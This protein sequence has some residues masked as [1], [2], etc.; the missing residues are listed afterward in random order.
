MNRLVTLRLDRNG[1]TEKGIMTIGRTIS[2]ALSLEFFSLCGNEFTTL[3]MTV[4]CKGLAGHPSIRTLLLEDNLGISDGSTKSLAAMLLLNQTLETLSLRNT[5]ITDVGLHHLLT[6]LRSARPPCA[7]KHLNFSG[8]VIGIDG[9]TTLCK[10][11]PWIQ[12]LVHLEL[13]SVP[14][15]LDSVCK[16]IDAC[17]QA[18]GLRRIFLSAPID[19]NTSEEAS[20]TLQKAIGVAS[21]VKPQLGIT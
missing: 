18:Q 15:T 7:M 1:I 17:V 4:L 16:L 20:H 12:S 2:M 11:I 13:C 9:V 8:L 19:V 3:S 14:L 21:L 6:C 5:N 10:C